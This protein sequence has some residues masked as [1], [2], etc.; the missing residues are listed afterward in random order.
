MCLSK[1]LKITKTLAYYGTQ[2][3]TAIKSFMIHAHGVNVIQLFSLN[4]WHF[5]VLPKI[6]TEV[7][8]IDELPDY[9]IG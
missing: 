7:T 3:I 1:P 8:P 6:I 9:K 2:F 4:L 5:S